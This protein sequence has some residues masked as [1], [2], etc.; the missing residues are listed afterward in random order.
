MFP[1]PATR[2]A[3]DA[4]FFFNSHQQ[5]KWPSKSQRDC[6][7]NIFAVSEPSLLPT[8]VP[9]WF[10]SHPQLGCSEPFCVHYFAFPPPQ[11]K[12]KYVP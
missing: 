1:L 3:H 10:L 12:G 11:K 8:S 4:H 7:K 5:K 9:H 6:Q 2:Q